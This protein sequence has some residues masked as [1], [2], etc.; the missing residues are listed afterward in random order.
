[1]SPIFISHGPHG[2]GCTLNSRSG[3]V[4]NQWFPNQKS[5]CWAS[6]HDLA[7][8]MKIRSEIF[9][10]IHKKTLS[11]LELLFWTFIMFLAQYFWT[12]FPSFT[13][14][15]FYEAC[16]TK[17]EH[18]KPRLFSSEETGMWPICLHQ[19]LSCENFDC[20]INNSRKKTLGALF[21]RWG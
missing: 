10:I 9:G 7:R 1:M 5:D 20:N 19:S 18:R 2:T 15:L 21:D 12:K 13:S 6:I 11:S 4:T 3:H 17:V 8:T 14:F 16:L